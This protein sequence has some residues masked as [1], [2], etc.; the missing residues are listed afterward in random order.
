[1]DEMHAIPPAPHH[2]RQVIFR[3]D[4]KRAGT[5]RNT[6]L[7]DIDST[8]DKGVIVFGRHDPRQPQKREGGIIGMATHTNTNLA[9][10]RNNFFEKRDQIGPQRIGVD[11]GVG[12][13]QG[14]QII[15]REV[16]NRPRQTKGN[17]SFQ[18]GTAFVRHF[19]KTVFGF[20][21]DSGG[22][23]IFRTGTVQDEQVKR[24]E[25]G[26]VKTHA[27]RTVG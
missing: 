26:Q 15:Q 1:M 5:Q 2:P 24:D 16:F 10:D 14:T 20:G 12:F 11:R 23:V 25:I 19:G 13:K 18:L 8:H 22:I 17:R 9:R 4:T 21:N 6:V 27:G 7:R 3:T